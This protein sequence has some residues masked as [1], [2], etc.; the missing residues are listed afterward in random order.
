MRLLWVLLASLITPLSIP[1][2]SAGDAVCGCD[3]KLQSAD[4][5]QLPQQQYSS[6]AAEPK[7]SSA[8]VAQPR[9]LS[10]D[11]PELAT[12]VAAKAQ[13]ATQQ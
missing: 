7:G 10:P 9:Q 6:Q 11:S 12:A 13:A 1:L 3:Q 2:A 4:K 5:S 8:Q